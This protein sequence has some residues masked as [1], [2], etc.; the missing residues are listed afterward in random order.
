M[1]VCESALLTILAALLSVTSYTDCKA[2]VIQNL[3]LRRAVIP[4]AALNVLYYGFLAAPYRTIFLLNA[5]LLI[6]IALLF[7]CYHLWGAGDSKLFIV[8]GLCLPGRLYTLWDSPLSSSFTVV[9]LVFSCAFLYVVGESVVLGI[10]HRNLL[11]LNTEAWN[12]RGALRS[13]F[14]MVG[15]LTL[16]N[17]LLSPTLS[18]F[19][20]ALSAAVNFLL[21]LTLIQI[22][23]KLPPAVVGFASVSV[24]LALSLL[25]LWHRFSWTVTVHDKSWVVVFLVMLSRMAAEKY[26][27]RAIPTEEVRAGQILS[28]GTVLGFT[29]SRIRGLPSGRTEDLRSRLTPEEADAVRRWG[30]SAR[31]KPWIVIVRKMPFAIFIAVGYAA[32]VT[33]EVVMP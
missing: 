10:R 24:W 14:A 6:V 8:A 1:I 12:I 4:A 13:D 16:A 33:L 26:N 29:A 23:D 9:I 25:T 7:Y 17:F 3:H 27:Y 28:A 2:G 18:R 19:S 32:F 20:P 15:A 30:K 5:A 21:V 31:G 11:S 22:R